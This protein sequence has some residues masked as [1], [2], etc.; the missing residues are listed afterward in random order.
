MTREKTPC[1][2]KNYKIRS[3]KFETRNNFKCPKNRKIQNNQTFGFPDWD[4][5]LF[6]ISILGFRIFSIDGE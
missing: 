4:L 1:I 6:R 2:Y 3:S 5:G